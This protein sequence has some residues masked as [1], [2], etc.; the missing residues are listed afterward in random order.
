M[1]RRFVEAGKTL[2]GDVGKEGLRFGFSGLRAG[3]GARARPGGGNW[4]SMLR[5]FGAELRWG[6]TFQL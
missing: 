2:G 3:S 5:D 1:R 4:T 6:S